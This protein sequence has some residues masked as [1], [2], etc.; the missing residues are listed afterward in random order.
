MVDAN[1]DEIFESLASMGQ[2]LGNPHRLKMVSLLSHG[3]KTVER[4]AGAIGQSLAA[5][6]AHLKVLRNAGL[7]TAEKRGRHVHYR[8]A[9]DEVSALWLALRD[10]GERL[11]PEVREAIGWLSGDGDVLCPLDEQDVWEQVRQGRG[12]LVDLRPADE[13]AAGHLPEACHLPF[14]ELDSRA[15]ELPTGRDLLVYCRGPYCLMAIEGVRQLRT[16]EYPARRLRFSVP[17]W[18]AAGLPVVSS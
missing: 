13:Y 16:R 18:K 17:E 4:L 9:G 12:V 3:E 8:L 1:K 6:S 5:T 2:A 10:L 7:V 14:E 15:R 11:R